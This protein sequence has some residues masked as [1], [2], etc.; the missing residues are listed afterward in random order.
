[1]CAWKTLDNKLT[2][3]ITWLLMKINADMSSYMQEEQN[4]I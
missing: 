1:M 3:Q 2:E 4:N